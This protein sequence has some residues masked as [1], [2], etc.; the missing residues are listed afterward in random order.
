MNC[1]HRDINIC[2]FFISLCLSTNDMKNDNLSK[3]YLLVA[4]IYC[5]INKYQLNVKMKSIK[6]RR[7]ERE[8]TPIY[9]RES[10]RRERIWFK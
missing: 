6:K 5:I 7:W 10:A 1:H 9:P 3:K 4:F 2:Y 8:S